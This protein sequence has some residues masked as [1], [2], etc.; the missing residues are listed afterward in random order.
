VNWLVLSALLAAFAHLGL[1]IF[2][3]VRGRTAI[4]GITIRCDTA[5][6]HFWATLAFYVAGAAFL[7][8]L[9]VKVE[10]QQHHCTASHGSC[11]LPVSET[12]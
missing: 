11:V 7:F 4:N 8:L 6:R 9:S 10:A 5:P 2:D 12:P 3:F 1:N